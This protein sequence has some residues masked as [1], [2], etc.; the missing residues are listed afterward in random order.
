MIEIKAVK[1]GEPLPPYLAGLPLSEG[2]KGVETVRK[3]LYVSGCD[4]LAEG[5]TFPA[6][7]RALL[8]H[9]NAHARLAAG[10]VLY[11]VLAGTFPDAAPSDK[12]YKSLSHA[13][14]LPDSWEHRASRLAL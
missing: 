11:R 13:E 7:H 9:Y 6:I 10:M 14:V 2:A 1:Q 8:E 12:A 5:A 4:H 3:L